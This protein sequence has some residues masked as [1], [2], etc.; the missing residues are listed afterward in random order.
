MFFVP[1]V[2]FSS[3]RRMGIL[4]SKVSWIHRVAASKVAS[5]IKITLR[6]N[7]DNEYMVTFA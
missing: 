5:Q 3:R 6:Y 1:D 4:R 7:S 2:T